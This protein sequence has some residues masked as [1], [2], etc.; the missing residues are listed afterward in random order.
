MRPRTW[1]AGSQ[2]GSLRGSRAA[3]DAGL[4]S[5]LLLALSILL[6]PPPPFEQALGNAGLLAAVGWFVIAAHLAQVILG[7]QAAGMV[8]RINVPF[9]AAE[10]LGACVAAIAQVVGDRQ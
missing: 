5:L 9:P 7:G 8:M 4:S 3:S 6:Q 1:H 10:A 2:A